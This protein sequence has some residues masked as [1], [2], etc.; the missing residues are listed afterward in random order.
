MQAYCLCL[1]KRKEH[2]T[3]L[4]KQAESLNIDFHPFIVGDGQTLPTNEYDYIDDRNADTSNWRYGQHKHKIN[5]YNAFMAHKKI[6]ERVKKENLDYFLMLEDDCY[7]TSRYLDIFNQLAHT[8]IDFNL[9][10]FGWWIGDENDE[11]NKSIE[12]DYKLNKTCGL[13]RVR[14]LGGLHAAVIHKSMYDYILSLPPIDPIDS[15]LNKIHHEIH[16]YLVFPKII[17]IKSIHSYCEGVTF[18]RNFI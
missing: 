11:W 12:E 1:D 3:E 15:Q 2:W 5:H 6:I 17:H 13:M 7:F 18:N 4:A 10:Y 16:S 8:K 14:Q 9:L